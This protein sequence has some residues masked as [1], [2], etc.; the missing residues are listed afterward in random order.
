MATIETRRE[1]M[2][3]ARQV[4]L[5]LREQVGGVYE[6]YFQQLLSQEEAGRLIREYV[7]LFVVD[8]RDGLQNAIQVAPGVEFDTQNIRLIRNKQREESYLGWN[9]H[10]GL[11]LNAIERTLRRNGCK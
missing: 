7:G 10:G 9:Y 8:H 11:V 6:K 3:W 2:F 5:P 1:E 4:L